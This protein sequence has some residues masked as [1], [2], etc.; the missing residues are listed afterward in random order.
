MPFREL[1]TDRLT[2]VKKDGTVVR[3]GIP[4]TVSSKKIITDD[5]QLPIEVGDSF[6]RSLPNGLVEN[7]V[8]SDPGFHRGVAGAIPAHYQSIVRRSDAP[9]PQPQSIVANFHGAN[10]RFNVNSTDASVN[11]ASGINTDQLSNFISQVRASLAGLPVE[12]KDAIAEPLAAL[13]IEVAS[14]TPSMSNIRMALMSIKAVMEGA[15]GNLVAMGIGALISK[16]F[17]G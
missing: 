4:A 3:E 16:M 7:Y 12:Q 8:V 10:S 1:M 11:V 13:D 17:G 15:A 6:V 2:F 14:P 9:V 5:V